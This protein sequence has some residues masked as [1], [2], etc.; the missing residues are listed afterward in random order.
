MAAAIRLRAAGLV[1]FGASR[2][3]SIANAATIDKPP[4]N[5]EPVPTEPLSTVWSGEL[6]PREDVEDDVAKGIFTRRLRLADLKGDLPVVSIGHPQVLRKF[7]GVTPPGVADSLPQDFY[8][9]RLWCSFRDFDS[10]LQFDRA[11]FKA[12]LTSAA[13]E[14]PAVVASG[15]PPV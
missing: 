14:A 9:V 6:G 3:N 11:V 1:F 10:D 5:F 15:P 12:A 7:A 4:M 2:E 8:V 13:A